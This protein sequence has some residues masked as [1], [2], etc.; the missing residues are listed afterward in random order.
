M[1]TKEVKAN[2]TPKKGMKT[3]ENASNAKQKIEIPARPKVS[4]AGPLINPDNT[5]KID[6]ADPDDLPDNN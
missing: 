5:F 2:D 1:T 4:R 6:P 3:K